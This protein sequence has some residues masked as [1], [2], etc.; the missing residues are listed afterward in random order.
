MTDRY[1]FR[2]RYVDAYEQPP[3]SPARWDYFRP[4]GPT[5]PGDLPKIH[6]TLQIGKPKFTS[7]YVSLHQCQTHDFQVLSVPISFLSVSYQ[8]LSVPISSYQL[9]C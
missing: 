9:T 6:S 7:S 4:H 8:F 3:S 2:V 1:R 5:E